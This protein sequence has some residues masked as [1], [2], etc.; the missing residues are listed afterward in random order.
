MHPSLFSFFR[1]FFL[2]SFVA[3]GFPLLAQMDSIDHRK[4]MVKDGG[5][6]RAVIMKSI[7]LATDAVRITGTGKP[8]EK[9]VVQLARFESM[10]QQ[11]LPQ[12]FPKGTFLWISPDHPEETILMSGFYDSYE[13]ARLA[14]AKWRQQ[15][16]FKK[17]FPRSKPFMIVYE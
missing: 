6:S 13:D 1:F 11:A 15:E 10:S 3:T 2:L 4:V 8:R 12:E 7:P 14:A 5:E 9:F 16:M 17:A